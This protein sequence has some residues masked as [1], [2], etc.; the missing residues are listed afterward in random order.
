MSVQGV[1]GQEV[2]HDREGE[3]MIPDMEVLSVARPP[4]RR[5]IKD[6]LRAAFRPGGV[7]VSYLKRC[8]HFLPSLD[9]SPYPGSQVEQASLGDLRLVTEDPGRG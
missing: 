9:L 2:F 4:R 7:M 6:V 5:K 8:R 1:T 3:Q